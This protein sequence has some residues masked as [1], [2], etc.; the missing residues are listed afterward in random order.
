M[1]CTSKQLA[2]CTYRAEA[3]SR[4]WHNLCQDH[5][6]QLKLQQHRFEF[7]FKKENASR[8]TSRETRRYSSGMI[9]C[10]FVSPL[11]DLQRA[12]P[13]PSPQR[14]ASAEGNFFAS[15]NL[16]ECAVQFTSPRPQAN[17]SAIVVGSKASK[18]RLKRF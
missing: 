16:D 15:S 6:L 8:A 11:A 2:F 3:V 17:I 18:K 1:Y 5:H 4:T 10:S 9:N 14:P 13:T 7:L 12:S